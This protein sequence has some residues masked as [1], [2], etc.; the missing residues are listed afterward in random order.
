[1]KLPSAQK[2]S[3]SCNS[4]SIPSLKR[5]EFARNLIK[6][7]F[8]KDTIRVRSIYVVVRKNALLLPNVAALAELVHHRGNTKRETPP[9]HHGGD[10]YL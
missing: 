10:A 3:F 5:K 6:S 9:K 7:Y 1:M 8:G 4:L 2:P